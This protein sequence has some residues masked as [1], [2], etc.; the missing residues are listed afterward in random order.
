[1]SDVGHVCR[2]AHVWNDRRHEGASI[3]VSV[4]STEVGWAH[5]ASF[6]M[7]DSVEPAVSPAELPTARYGYLALRFST[8]RGIV[9]DWDLSCSCHHLPRASD[10]V[11]HRHCSPPKK[12][13]VC[14]GHFSWPQP[15]PPGTCLPEP[16]SSLLRGVVLLLG[17]STCM[18]RRKSAGRASDWNRWS[19]Q[20]SCQR[21]RYSSSV[22]RT[23]ARA[24][25]A[26]PRMTSPTASVAALPTSHQPAPP[27]VFG[28]V[29]T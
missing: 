8:C 4:T 24:M 7:A 27:V 22:T 6:S 18:A 11:P 16:A 10:N 26:A 2:P 15:T 3:R 14:V 20:R 13:N 5:A 1:M 12:A 21:M 29:G 28:S 23:P 17:R 25:P 19:G 9:S